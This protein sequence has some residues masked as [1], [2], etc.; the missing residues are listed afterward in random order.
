MK[1]VYPHETISNAGGS[2]NK[3]STP[4]FHE[5]SDQRQIKAPLCR[6]CGQRSLKYT[7]L[8]NKPDI[9][10]SVK[11]VLEIDIDIQKDEV[12]L[13]KICCFY[14]VLEE[15]LN[16]VFFVFQLGGYPSTVCLKCLGLLTHLE[17]FRSSVM[18]GQASLNDQI[19]LK[20][21]Q[22]TRWFQ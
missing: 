22:L 19:L 10:Q 7:E 20:L 8:A 16:L 17:N 1:R 21:L 15:K 18:A 2:P 14:E 4:S 6:L 13:F 5:E 12:F 3:R 11:T 9:I